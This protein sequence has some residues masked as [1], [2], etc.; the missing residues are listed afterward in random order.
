MK[1]FCCCV[2]VGQTEDVLQFENFDLEN[3]I[4]PVNVQVFE[5]LLTQA[6]YDPSEIN[7]LVNGFTNGFSIE[8]KGDR[9]V[10]K[11]SPNLQLRVG[12]PIELW[13]KVMTEVQLG[14][15]AGPFESPPYEHFIQSPNG[16]VPKDKGTKTRLIF[17]LSYPRTGSTSVNS[18][19]P[20]ELCTVTYPSL[21]EA[22]KLCIENGKI[23]HVQCF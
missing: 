4:T 5:Q 21:D 14:R 8:Y 17:H 18:E 22:I 3:I 19:I 11:L 13:N 2:I 9:N 10:R 1:Q 6:Q 7:Y 23:R 15:Y 16:L 20:H 12:S